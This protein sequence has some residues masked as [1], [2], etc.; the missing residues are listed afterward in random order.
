MASRQL[1]IDALKFL[2]AH[3]IVLHHAA[4]YGPLS[5]GLAAAF[6][7]LASWLVSHAL[8]VVHVFLAVGGFLAARSL[9]EQAVGMRAW[10]GAVRDRFARTM[11]PYA[12]ALLLAMV[13]SAVARPWLPGD[14]IPLP[15]TG[16]QVLA[17][18]GFLQG[19]LHFD[20]LS[21]GVWYVAMDFQLFAV[22]AGLLA[23]G[24][25]RRWALVLLLAVASMLI[26]NRHAG[27]DDWAVYFFGSYGLGALAFKASRS[28][29]AYRWLALLALLG[30]L[31]LAVEMRD[32]LL[33]ALAT[34]LYLGLREVR[35]RTRP[36]TSQA[37]SSAS[38]W[39][40]RLASVVVH[41]G[42]CSYA[43]FLIHFPVLMLANVL[44]IGLGK[45]QPAQAVGLL[46][47]AWL[48]S[49][50]MAMA[51]YRWV[52]LPLTRLAKTPRLNSRLP[53]PETHA[54]SQAS[55]R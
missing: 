42:A 55:M 9:S 25:K 18:L 52:E 29:Q 11:P 44:S 8:K 43:L 10:S 23:L 12:A 15:P 54:P 17:H 39:R 1:H 13:C 34:A 36:P 26:F 30:L 41:Q 49:T 40:V 16:W 21:A 32:R 45:S 20:S 33:L 50:V 38:A 14:F 48:V 53:A 31:A 6:P 37:P 47:L 7:E 46:L 19:I 3:A 27:L 28:P 4:L 24:S 51:F 22:L 35:Y 2:A 5:E